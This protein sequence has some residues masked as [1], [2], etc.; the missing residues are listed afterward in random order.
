MCVVFHAYETMILPNYVPFI[1]YT[2]G[3]DL[4]FTH[5]LCMF[6]MCVS[7]VCFKCVSCVFHMYVSLLCA[8]RAHAAPLH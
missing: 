7:H 5:D 1:I 2:G 3:D 8:Y 6:H 4:H